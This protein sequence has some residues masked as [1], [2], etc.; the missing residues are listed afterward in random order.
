MGQLISTVAV[1]THNVWYYN[2]L[3][4]ITQIPAFGRKLYR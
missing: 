2:Y 4:I 3:G 1:D